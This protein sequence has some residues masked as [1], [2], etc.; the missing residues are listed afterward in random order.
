M[1]KLRV[2]EFEL[3]MKIRNIG[4]IMMLACLDSY[5]P[6]LPCHTQLEGNVP[7]VILWLHRKF[8]LI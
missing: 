8:N 4:K 3:G 7:V 1:K 5:T 6:L 2:L